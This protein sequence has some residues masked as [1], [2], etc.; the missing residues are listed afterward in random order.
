MAEEPQVFSYITKVPKKFSDFNTP[1]FKDG[2]RR[3]Y[4]EIVGDKGIV[5]LSISGGVDST[6]AAYLLYPILGKRLH[7][8]FVNDGLRRRIGGR[9]EYEVTAGMFRDFPNFEVLHIAD[10]LLPKLDGVSDGRRKREIMIESYLHASNGYIHSI[11]AD[12]VADGTI[13]PDIETTR[14]GRQRQH[15]VD[16]PYRVGKL[17]PLASLYKPQVR[18]LARGLG[19]PTEFVHRIPCPGPAT[20]LR[21]GGVFNM[22]KLQLAKEATDEVEQA[23]EKYFAGEWGHPYKYDEDTGVRTP[24]QYFGYAI[25]P[26]MNESE[27]MSRRLSDTAGAKVRCYISDTKAMMIDPS[28]ERQ[29]EE[30]YQMIAWLETGDM[31]DFEKLNA[32]GDVLEKAGF[33]RAVYQVADGKKDGFPVGIKVV[34]S[35]DA[36]TAKTMEMPLDY[37]SEVGAK[38][39]G[40]GASRSGYEISRKPPVTIELF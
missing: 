38:I 15:N 37:I 3:H 29:S 36:I 26:G 32:M 19:L 21:I 31:L 22:E 25:D 20:L 1:G 11:G 34:E 6:T 7:L 12:F 35:D 16:I 23:V 5:A 9:E 14:S 4:S 18:R 24:F 13:R 10:D 27:Q 8:F 30:L 17:Q 33:P 40:Y 2:A 28:V 39:A